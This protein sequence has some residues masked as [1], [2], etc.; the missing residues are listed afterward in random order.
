VAKDSLLGKDLVISYT[1]TVTDASGSKTTK[2]FS[3][4]TEK[5][6]EK[7]LTEEKKKHPLGEPYEHVRVIPKGWEIDVEGEVVDTTPDDIID[8]IEAAH[9]ENRPVPE[10]EVYKEETYLDGTVRRYKYTSDGGVRI[11]GFEKSADK[12]SEAI[13]YKFKINAMRREPVK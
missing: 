13:K 10:I 11:S 2:A 9:R 7:Q 12:G 5:F 1:K 8:E 6:D 3:L 4:E